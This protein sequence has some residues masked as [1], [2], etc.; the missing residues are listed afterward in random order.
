VEFE[1]YRK[2]TSFSK[3]EKK[4]FVVENKIQRRVNW[5][6][7]ENR[8]KKQLRKEV[9]MESLRFKPQY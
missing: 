1:G 4:P 3:S 8:S 2:P 5:F 9:I 6:E 7:E